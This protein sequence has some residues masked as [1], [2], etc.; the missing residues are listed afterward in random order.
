MSF[1]PPSFTIFSLLALGD[2]GLMAIALVI[3]HI[4]IILFDAVLIPVW[5]CIEKRKNGEKSEEVDDV[6]ESIT[7]NEKV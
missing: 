6:E 4:S 5:L 7:M 3:C 1:P 2:Q